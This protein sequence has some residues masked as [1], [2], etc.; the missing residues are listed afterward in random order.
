M[1]ATSTLCTHAGAFKATYKDLKAMKDPEKLG[2]IHTPVRHDIFVD[3]LR[4]AVTMAG[5]K[6]KREEFA[7]MRGGA[8]LFGVMD[9]SSEDG[10]VGACMGFRHG[11]DRSMRIKVVAGI[12]VFVCDNM[13]LS[14]DQVLLNYLHTRTFDPKAECIAAVSQYLEARHN[15]TSTI[16]RMKDAKITDG[17]AKELIYDAIV[18]EDVLPLRM[19]P[20]VDRAYFAA[21]TK[22]VAP[23][24]VWGLHNSFTRALQLV[25]TLNQ[26]MQASSDTT[27]VLAQVVR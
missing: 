19:L 9:F 21:E 4:E 2:R 10:E 25:P 3:G 5:L 22:D 8:K 26:Q 15:F 27:K 18:R 13:A 17:R 24:T 11:N 16:D 20:E 1:K 7:I 6:I 23:R 14:G 12:R